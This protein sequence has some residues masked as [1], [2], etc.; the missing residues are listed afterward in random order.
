MSQFQSAP[1]SNVFPPAQ[2]RLAS[3][4]HACIHELLEAQV[5]R[6]GEST[7]L[8]FEDESLTYQELNHRA[9]KLARYLRERGVGPEVLVGVCMDRSLDAIVA[10]LAILKAGGAYVPLDPSYPKERI[11]YILSD[12]GCSLLI[13]HQELL[14]RIPSTNAELLLLDVRWSAIAE[15]PGENLGRVVNP[16]NL[17]YVIYTSGSTGKPK[18]VQVEHYSVVNLLLSMQDETGIDETDVVAAVT[19]LCFDIA[20][21]EIYLPLVSGARIAIVKRDEGSDGKKLQDRIQRAGVTLLQGTPAL[22]RILLETG[23]AGDRRL[24]VISGGE[25]F[26]REIANTLVSRCKS[27]WNGYG[28][29]ETTIYSSFYRITG[30]GEG[31]VPIGHPVRD[32]HFHIVDDRMKL[33]PSGQEGQ[34]LIGGVGVARGYL[35]LKELTEEKFISDP[36]CAKPGARL[37]KTG[38]LARILPDGNIA[39]L[40]RMDHQVKIR[41]YRIELGEIEF[42]LATHPSVKQ[43]VVVARED[44][45]GDKR[46][47]A[48]VVAGPEKKPVARVLREFLQIKLPDYMVPASFVVLKAMPLTPNGKVDRKALPVPSRDNSGFD[49]EYLPPRSSLE[50]KLV[51]IWEGALGIKPIGIRD[52]IFELGVDSVI[53][54]QLFARIEKSLAKDLPPAPLFRAPTIE[55]LANLLERE[56][57]SLRQWTSLVAIQ[58]RG[59]K[60]PLF[61]VHGAAGTALLFQPLA[62]RLAD[63]CPVYAFQAQGLYGRDMPHTSIEEMAAHYIREMRTVQ[64]QGPYL[65]SG[66]CFGGLVVFEMAQQ[67]MRMGERVEMLAMLNAPSAPE[68]ETRFS[69]PK[70]AP[71]SDRARSRWREFRS[72]STGRKVRY[73]WQKLKG[74]IVWRSSAL[75]QGTTRFIYRSMITVRHRV[76]RYYIKRRIPLPDFMRN[77]YFIFANSRL[78]RRYKHQPYPGNIVVFRDQLPYSDPAQGWGRFTRDIEVVEI[79]VS[80]KHHRGL[81]QEPAVGLLAQKIKEYLNRRTSLRSAVGDAA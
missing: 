52:N 81:L 1:S 72:L 54:A 12:A 70:L 43:C 59:D 79:P 24:K 15:A 40:G 6:R 64:P 46:L 33:V 38:D 56:N 58:P 22:F 50:K 45:P 7:A 35:G 39:F 68:Y 20:G 9:N 69:E 2:S 16:R 14:T 3:G 5:L 42:A 34:L 61:C 29:T 19:T 74:Q 47:V 65:L 30:V 77:R 4:D 17:A 67:L 41:G 26:P 57:T 55:L 31:N 78:E 62:N 21:L 10:L 27:V 25:A 37:Y 28:P 71:I 36:F 48:Y 60:A 18:G 53:A 75:Y 66:W 44:L 32:T 11:E 76:Y 51:R 63:D 23:W 8:F 73:A 13:T 80:V 49:H